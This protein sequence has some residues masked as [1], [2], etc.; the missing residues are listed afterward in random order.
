MFRAFIAKLDPK[1]TEH[2]ALAL[3]AAELT[4]SAEQ[5][6]TLLLAG[7]MTAEPTVVRLENTAR[8]ARD[9]LKVSAA[10]QPEQ[11]PK[12]IIEELYAPYRNKQRDD[13]SSDHGRPVG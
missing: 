13:N 11:T 7:D 9:D 2:V 12:E 5:A 6:R 8:R 3:A 4:V 1:N 10:A